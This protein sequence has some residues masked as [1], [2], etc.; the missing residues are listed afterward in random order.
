MSAISLLLV[1]L[2]VSLEVVHLTADMSVYWR[3]IEVERQR[4]ESCEKFQHIRLLQHVLDTENYNIE[5]LECYIEI[6]ML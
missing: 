3:F 1:Y 5:R 6:P 2:F 4:W